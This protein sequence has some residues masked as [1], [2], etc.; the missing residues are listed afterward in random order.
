MTLSSAGSCKRGSIWC[1]LLTAALSGCGESTPSPAGEPKSL[2]AGPH[3]QLEPNRIERKSRSEP[4][5]ATEQSVQLVSHFQSQAETQPY[6]RLTTVKL[7]QNTGG[8]LS[9]PVL[10]ALV[11]PA[12]AQE[13]RI[14]E[15]EAA[16][17]TARISATQSLSTDG[18]GQADHFTETSAEAPPAVLPWGPSAPTSELTAVSQRAEET[19]RN[20][21]NLA[22]RAALYTAR[23]QFIE[24]LRTLAAALD[25]QRQTQAHCRALAN[26]LTALEEVDDFV[27]QA[28]KL[29]SNDSIKF[30]VD[31]HRT[32]VLKNRSLDKVT[33]L[34]AK[35]MYLTYAQ[36]QLAAAGGDQPVASL[37]LYGLG[38]VCTAPAALHGPRDQ[39]AEGKAVVLYQAALIISPENFMAA[40]ELGVMLAKFGRFQEAK[41]SLAHAAALSNSPI[42]WR[43]LAVVCQRSGDEPRAAQARQ[44]ANYIAAELQK[45]GQINAGSQYP[46]KWVDPST[47]AQSHSSLA[48]Q[49]D[50]APAATTPATATTP[51]TAAKPESKSSGWKWPWQ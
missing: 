51:T 50:P 32:P 33:A 23:S 21:F 24:A 39:V 12:T 13:F 37:A 3:H 27:P 22:E 29:I 48:A 25:A 45:A 35:K 8:R 28:G 4:Q 49:A 17:H 18:L 26:G 31:G 20:G 11:N 15:N 10:P 9:E 7:A 38:K 2:V 5:A 47:F 36:E 40:N 30:I 1:L 42:A 34:E 14:D 19:V 6:A 41:T 44:Q 43:N 46:V 16:R